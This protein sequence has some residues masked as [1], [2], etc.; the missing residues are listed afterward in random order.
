[1][2]YYQFN[3]SDYQSH[4]RHLTVVEDCCYRRML[5]WIYLHE[6]PLPQDPK[7]VARILILNECLTDVERVLNEYFT[8]VEQ[9]WVNVRALVEIDAFND[10]LEKASKAGKAS[11]EA[12][13]VKIKQTLKDSKQT[14]N[15]RSTDVQPNK[16][17][18]TLTINQ[19]IYSDFDEFWK[20]YPKKTG[21]DIALKSWL[22]LKPNINEVLK[23]LA[24]QIESDQW[25]EKDGKF[26]PNPATYLNQGRWKDEPKFEGVPF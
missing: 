15:E 25:Q 16:K 26:I 21:K 12:R 22:K 3:I 9:G 11:A 5:D 18:E 23:A 19:Y 6:K 7:D 14:F 10:K 8:L 24:W 17:Q 1:L 2:H 20:N 4:T 13:K